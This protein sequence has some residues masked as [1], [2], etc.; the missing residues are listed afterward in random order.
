MRDPT[1]SGVI[2]AVLRWNS[3]KTIEER[4]WKQDWSHYL[5][6]IKSKTKLCGQDRKNNY[7]IM[8]MKVALRVKKEGGGEKEEERVREGETEGHRGRKGKG[9]KGQRERGGKRKKRKK[10]GEAETGKGERNLRNGCGKWPGKEG[11]EL[12]RN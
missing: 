4:M 11:R 1:S 12:G 3:T 5:K 6:E 7:T 9:G 2:G 10:R 8:K